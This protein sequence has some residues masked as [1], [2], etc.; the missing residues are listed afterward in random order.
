MQA[1]KQV[2]N[3]QNNPRR[4]KVLVTGQTVKK[5][6]SLASMFKSLLLSTIESPDIVHRD[7]D[8]Q[9]RYAM[10]QSRRSGEPRA[11]LWVCE[12]SSI[13]SNEAATVSSPIAIAG[14]STHRAQ[15]RET[16]ARNMI[17]SSMSSSCALQMDF[18]PRVSRRRI[19]NLKS[20]SCLNQRDGKGYYVE[21]AALIKTSSKDSLVLVSL[22]DSPKLSPVTRVPNNS[23]TDSYL[24]LWPPNSHAQESYAPV[25]APRNAGNIKLSMPYLSLDTYQSAQLT[26]DINEALGSELQSSNSDA[27]LEGVNGGDRSTNNLQKN[28]RSY[29]LSMRSGMLESCRLVGSP[30]STRFLTRN[31]AISCHTSSL[32][33]GS[34]RV[35]SSLLYEHPKQ[36]SEPLSVSYSPQELPV[37]SSY[38]SEPCFPQK[39][40]A[41]TPPIEE[42]LLIDLSYFSSD[43]TPQ[44]TVAFLPESWSSPESSTAMSEFRFEPSVDQIPRIHPL[45]IQRQQRTTSLPTNEQWSNQSH[46]LFGSTPPLYCISRALCSRSGASNEI[47]AGRENLGDGRREDIES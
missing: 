14:P 11:V 40:P 37:V 26:A 4:T 47:T 41:E 44:R 12:S 8:G 34:N 29:S 45:I 24:A 39:S 7:F 38:S 31:R 42:S 46:S 6:L 15:R 23:P 27:A 18:P 28:C 9:S 3:L 19:A 43:T 1:L 2:L 32:S 25:P 35:P 17:T 21:D 36:H 30:T 5:E 22:G 16:R 20:K 13:S 10:E 33:S